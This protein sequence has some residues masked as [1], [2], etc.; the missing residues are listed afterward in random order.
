MVFD[1]KIGNISFDVFSTFLNEVEQDFVPPLLSRIDTNAYFEKLSKYATLIGCYYKNELV[2]LSASYDNN[3]ESKLAFVT[4]IAVKSAFRGNNIASNILSMLEKHAKDSGMT[5]VGIDTNNEVAK[6][7]YLKNGY[8]LKE[9]H[10]LTE[11]NLT[12]YYLEK[13]I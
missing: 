6:L 2:G 3:L 1:Y 4:F 8:T 5:I 10:R 7:C 11:Y 9:Q 13:N 12:R